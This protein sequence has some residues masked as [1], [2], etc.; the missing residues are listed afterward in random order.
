MQQPFGHLIKLHLHLQRR[1][2]SF[3]PGWTMLAGALASGALAFDSNRT[4]QL[5]LLWLLVDPV[6]GTVWELAVQSGIWRESL[7][8]PLP[9]GTRVSLH[10][11]PYATPGSW[12][13]RLARW[14][15]VLRAWWRMAPGAAHGQS[16]TAFAGS[17]ILALFLGLFLKPILIP[18]ILLSVVLALLT[19]R[20]DLSTTVRGQRFWQAV[21]NVVIPWGMGSLLFASSLPLFSGLLMVCYGLVYLGGLRQAAGQSEGDHLL[22]MGQAAA[23]LLLIGLRAP[24]SAAVLTVVLLFQLILRNQALRRGAYLWYLNSIQPYMVIG[25][26][27]AAWGVS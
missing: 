22:V 10:L 14:W 13:Y 17:A 3:G 6:L 26:M 11:V 25:L 12:G 9:E 4:L 5:V 24:L 20:E 15:G 19:G 1:W 18:L 8:A 27:A 16:A 21:G 2:L 23:I 7:R